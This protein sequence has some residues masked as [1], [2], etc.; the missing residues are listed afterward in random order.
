MVFVA[1]VRE[2]SVLQV[3]YMC[4]GCDAN[5]YAIYMIRLCRRACVG[6]DFVALVRGQCM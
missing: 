3:V 2:S 6:Y 5:M 4:N 1:P